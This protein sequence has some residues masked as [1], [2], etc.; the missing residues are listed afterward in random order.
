MICFPG[1]IVPYISRFLKVAIPE[2][3]TT[4][5][6][7]ETLP[8]EDPGGEDDIE[9]GATSNENQNVLYVRLPEGHPIIT[10]ASD[11]TAS[12][13]PVKGDSNSELKMS[14]MEDDLE[15]ASV[16]LLEGKSAPVQ[17]S[18]SFEEAVEQAELI[19]DD[20]DNMED[21]AQMSV[22]EM[23]PVSASSVSLPSETQPLVSD[24]KTMT[25]DLKLEPVLSVAD[26]P[27]SISSLFDTNSDLPT[28]KPADNAA[29]DN[30]V[31]E[32]VSLETTTTPDS[33]NNLQATANVKIEKEGENKEALTIIKVQ[34]ECNISNEK[35]NQDVRTELKKQVL[36]HDSAPKTRNRKIESYQT[37]ISNSKPSSSSNVVIKREFSLS[38]SA[39]ATKEN[40]VTEVINS[41]EELA[42]S[43]NK[44]QNSCV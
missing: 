1:S 36:N 27:T 22:E 39:K 7:A 28:A 41:K 23:N 3:C 34:K 6:V 21:I 25:P 10:G 13:N 14:S 37:I 31:I 8:N 42:S 26:A 40:S 15:S 2:G 5:E 29:S 20:G 19:F 18:L 12:T 30:L 32:K 17:P 38:N 4:L 33:G 43:V 35:G 16:E 24:T 9:S 44:N 11:Q